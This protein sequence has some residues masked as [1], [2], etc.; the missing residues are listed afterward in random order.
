MHPEFWGPHGWIFLHSIT[1]EYPSQPTELDKKKYFEFFNNLHYVLP[2]VSCAKHY[3]EHLVKYPLTEEIL[4]NK[5]TLTQWLIQIHNEVNKSLG[6]PVL[7]M[8]EVIQ[9]YNQ[10]IHNKLHQNTIHEY[11][12]YCI[13]ISIII[14]LL[15]LYFMK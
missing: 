15:I 9:E 8:N 5:K 6:K 3:Q 7:T 14:C 1:F 13:L 11:I 2:C 10:K 4:Q 12:P